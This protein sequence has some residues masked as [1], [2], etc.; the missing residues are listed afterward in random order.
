MQVYDTQPPRCT[1]NTTKQ[2]TPALPVLGGRS[3][4]VDLQV[5]HSCIV[6]N[7][8]VVHSLLRTSLP[9]LVQRLD[10]RAKHD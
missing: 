6:V 8:N 10:L 7:I 4:L 1:K 3:N 5:P 9:L 2:W